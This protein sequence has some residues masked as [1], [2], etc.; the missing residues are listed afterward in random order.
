M[1]I[2]V[3]W[4]EI[5][6]PQSRTPMTQSDPNLLIFLLVLLLLYSWSAIILFLFAIGA[7]RRRQPRT[8]RSQMVSNAPMI[9]DPPTHC[10]QKL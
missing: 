9:M 2:P 5:S 1:K 4:G 10:H 8:H 3:L 7:R 6:N